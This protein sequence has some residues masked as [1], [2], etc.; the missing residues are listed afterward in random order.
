MKLLLFGAS[1]RTGQIVAAH[2]LRA[3]MQVQMP[4]HTECDLTDTRAVSDAVLNAEADAVVNC[5]AV[6]SI[7]TCAEDP[8]YAHIVNAMAPAA[9][10][11]AC[12]HTGSRFIHL[13]TD[14]VLDGRK[15]GIR[16]EQA[17]CRPCNTYAESKREGELQVLEALPSATICRVSWV[18]GNP[19]RPAFIESTLLNALAGR[20]VAA[21]ADKVSQPTD[22]EDIARVLLL[23]A[24]RKH[25]G[26]LHLCSGGMPLSWHDCAVIALRAAVQAG[27]LPEMPEVKAQRLADVPFFREPRPRYTAMSNEKLISMGIDM[28]TGEETVRRAALRYLHSSAGRA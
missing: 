23:L 8:V 13:S 26:I 24:A 25:P 1:G 17:K 22:A 11:L 14:Y 21:I 4:T 3:G 12:R 15:P 2:A 10:A 16:T 19:E 5:A 9:M 6:S 18:C 7:E 28:P 27:F 20:S